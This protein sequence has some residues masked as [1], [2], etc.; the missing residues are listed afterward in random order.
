MSVG[1]W[2]LNCLISKQ[3]GNKLELREVFNKVKQ[4]DLFGDSVTHPS[5]Q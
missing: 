2:N 1:H 4:F 3:F 5:F